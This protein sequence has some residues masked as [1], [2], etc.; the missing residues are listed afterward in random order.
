MGVEH[1]DN[2]LVKKLPTFFGERDPVSVISLMP[3][4]KK[5]GGFLSIRGGN[6]D[7][8]LVLL[9]D[10]PVYNPSHLLGIL[11]IFHA[12]AVKDVTLYK[13]TAPARYGGR[14]SGVVDA[15]SIIGDKTKWTA[16]AGIGLLSSRFSLS[17]P[18]QKGKSSV[19]IGG[20]RTYADLFLKLDRDFKGNALFFHDFNTKISFSLSPKDELSF[21]TYCGRDVLKIIDLLAI[22]WGNTLGVAHYKHRFSD[23]SQVNM[24]LSVNRYRSSFDIGV[25]SLGGTPIFSFLSEVQEWLLQGN[26][27]IQTPNEQHKITVGT[28]VL[29]RRNIPGQ[30]L[31]NGLADVP[32]SS[33]IRKMMEVAMFVQDNWELVPEK[34][35]LQTGLRLQTY[36]IIGGGG[37]FYT[38]DEKRETFT[39]FRPQGVAKTYVSVEPRLALHYKMTADHSLKASYNRNSQG[40]FLITN[41]T[42]SSPTDRWISASNN[43]PVSTSGIV[44]MGYVGNF[45]R[46]QWEFSVEG[47]YKGMNAI[48]DYKDNADQTDRV[49]ER[50]LLFG[51]GRAYGVEF[52]LRKQKGIAS[53]WLSYTLSRVQQQIPGVNKNHWYLARQ[54]RTHSLNVVGVFQLS[55][56]TM[57][58]V[59][60]IYMTGNAV[61]FPTGKYNFEGRT[62]FVY[63]DRNAGR[64]PPLHRMD[65]SLTY[66]L[67]PKR[68]ARSELVFSLYNAYARENPFVIH[69][70]EDEENPR[71]INAIQTSLARI[72]PSISW[73][74]IIL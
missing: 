2:T 27:Q 59:L 10:V 5:S 31:L 41:S 48:T 71:K 46:E 69:F 44:S 30:V 74:F 21:S 26:W 47:Y 23:R 64:M 73:N 28:S 67:K 61:S 49:I 43:I 33:I 11:S 15:H 37:D 18:I 70:Q 7:Q 45:F 63:T 66:R 22:N 52:L 72:I 68:W 9:D 24:S 14:M 32:Q 57:L 34:L 35:N 56:R 12:D 58:S 8:N 42:A 17:A 1:A 55:P 60:W 53:G 3:G 6:Y 29:R 13:G 20:R 50:Q 40:V 25:D 39:V 65:I 16:A 62:V 36:L 4:I 54:D 19:F 51:K 38:L